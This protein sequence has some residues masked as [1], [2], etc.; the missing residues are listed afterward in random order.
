MEITGCLICLDST[1]EVLD[2]AKELGYNLVIA[3]HPIVFSGLKKITGRTYVERTVLKAIKHNIAIYAIHTNLD[4]VSDG[5]NFKI[6]EKL[7]LQ[8]L[9][10][11]Q[12]KQGNLV[13][14]EVHVP[15]T[16]LEA[17]RSAVFEAG[18][19]HLGNYS[20]CSYSSEG[21]GTFK[22]GQNANPFVG[23]QGV[24]HK[25]M[26][27]KLE[28]ILPQ[29]LLSHVLHEVN[30]AH[31]YEEV[32]Y[33]AISLKN[34]WGSVGSGM[35]GELETPMNTSDFLSLVKEK[36]GLT[37]LKHTPLCK[38]MISKVALCGGSGSFLTQDAKHSGAD[39]YI[40]SDFKYHE[41]FDAE[42]QIILADIGHFESEQYTIE[43]LSDWLAEKF[44][45]FAVR[46]TRIVT[47]PINYF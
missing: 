18:A 15:Q 2:E 39:I 10:I 3:H 14:L 17:V 26:E 12:P 29:W 8:R 9:R 33:Q 1:E 38:K 45:T 27:A 4:N 41:F 16:H 47:N 37:V 35:V 43:L 11:L 5:V 19:G 42:D 34:S 23:E 24:R 46:K 31:P 20:E 30:E 22:A 13:K 25:E 40:S 28:V 6:A 36:F 32:A 7:G 21:E 44:P